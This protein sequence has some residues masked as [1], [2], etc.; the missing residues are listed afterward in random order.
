MK[1]I[2]TDTYNFEGLITRGYTYVDKTAVLYSLINDSIGSQFFLSRPRRFGKS[3][4][5]STFK[6]LFQGRRDL[7]K[8]LAIDSLE[9]DWKTYPV[10]HLDMGSMQAPTIAEFEEKLLNQLMS[11][12]KELDV[13]VEKSSIPSIVFMRL[14]EALAAKSPHKQFVMLV[15]EYDKPLL[16]TLNTPEVIKFRD[17]LKSFYSVIKTKESLMRFTFI[18]G[19]SKFSKV[20]IFSDLNNLIDIS[21]SAQFA[22]L[23]GYTHDEVK[24]F[25]P[26]WIEKLANALGVSVEEAFS[27]IVKWYDGYKFHHSAEPVIN[28]VSLGYCL[29]ESEFRTYWSS[30]AVPTFLVDLLKKRPVNLQL[31]GI[32]ES[33]LDAYEPTSLNPVTL[34]YQTGYL[35]ISSFS[36][37]GTRRIYSLDFPNMEVRNTFNTSLARGY[38]NIDEIHL[39]SLHSKCID[40][41]YDDKLD[42]FF[43]TLKVFFANIPYDISS[44]APEET[45]QA[46]FCA[47]LYFI[48]VGVTPEVRTNE[49]RIDAVME[50]PDHVYVM[51][52]KRDK[53][54]AEAMAQI[55]ENKYYEKFLASGK[56]ITLVGV[57]F[58]SEK[59]TIAE[60][61]TERMG[62]RNE[63]KR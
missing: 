62:C 51:E 58:D 25:F 26:D 38:I 48:G 16:G 14:C 17:A 9:Y 29:R 63:E 21:M 12:S 22:T 19:I 31:V 18:T 54:A 35:T 46:I 3:L 40:A 34:L 45:Y 41:L 33:T 53:S 59:R 20:S 10:L 37:R 24:K 32:D 49:G 8:G 28:P 50:T 7:F 55:K 60:W 4:L 56:K 1:P 57:N 47:I 27:E 11:L 13:E 39:G 5:I 61:V 30:T 2:A 23:L 36:Q 52:F 44:R 15:D 43:E 6:S 42:V